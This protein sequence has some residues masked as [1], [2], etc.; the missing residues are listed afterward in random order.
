MSELLVTLGSWKT[1]RLLKFG[2]KEQEMKIKNIGTNLSIL[3]L[4]GSMAFVGITTNAS[5]AYDPT[6]DIN[7]LKSQ[8]STLNYKI[9]SLESKV[10]SL[11]SQVGQGFNKSSSFNPLESKVSNLE[12]TVRSL[13]STIS[14]LQSTVNS[15]RR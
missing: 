9:S 5:A 4:A 11:S 6:Y 3:A 8:V 2:P 14:S 13:Q 12:S 10:S 15:I 1:K 7:S